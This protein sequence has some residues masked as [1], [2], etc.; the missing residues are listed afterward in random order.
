MYALKQVKTMEQTLSV[1][2]SYLESKECTQQ[3]SMD[4][5]IHTGQLVVESMSTSTLPHGFLTT[6]S[7]LSLSLIHI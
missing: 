5:V 6:I 3:L 2:C 4:L 7:A 1:Q